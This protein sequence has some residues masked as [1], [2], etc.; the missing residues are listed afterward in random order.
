M[1]GASGT[2]MGTKSL[3]SFTTSL[4]LK[5]KSNQNFLLGAG[6]ALSVPR[7]RQ[8]DRFWVTIPR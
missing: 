4:P 3:E 5:S 8:C 6:L 7:I 1:I 2:V